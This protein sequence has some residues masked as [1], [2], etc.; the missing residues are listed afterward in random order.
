M[1]DF[2]DKIDICE[3]LPTN[4]LFKIAMDLSLYEIM[5]LCNLSKKCNKKICRSEKFWY[6]KLGKDFPNLDRK[7]IF[8]MSWKETY[9]KMFSKLF[10]LDLDDELKGERDIMISGPIKKYLSGIMFMGPKG[11]GGLALTYDNK[12]SAILVLDKNSPPID[13][14]IA[15]ELSKSSSLKIVPDSKYYPHIIKTNV[16]DFFIYDGTIYIL[17]VNNNSYKLIVDVDFSELVTDN[18]N[19][20]LLARNV[21]QV[22]LPFIVSSDGYYFM[23][24]DKINEKHKVEHYPSYFNLIEKSIFEDYD[25]SQLVF[26]DTQGNLYYKNNGNI[27]QIS[28][29]VMKISGV[30]H[31]L[32]YIDNKHDLYYLELESLNPVKISRNVKDIKSNFALFT[33]GHMKKVY[34]DYMDNIKVGDTILRNVDQILDIFDIDYTN[35]KYVGVQSIYLL[36]WTDG[37]YS[38]VLDN[39][40]QIP[41]SSNIRDFSFY[42]NKFIYIDP[43][44]KFNVNIGHIE[45]ND[46]KLI[47]LIGFPDGYTFASP[48]KSNYMLK[49]M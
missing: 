1:C 44:L 6:F 12:L 11:T 34:I 42:N 35:I 18:L 29:N 5:E 39:M 4:T 33:N 14:N 22:K 32:Y 36:K 28:S 7:E 13:P 41:L 15:K 40:T 45:V 27:R 10:K 47:T 37:T 26:L 49:F 16:K 38:L 31:D 30:L 19:L 24:Y 25:L 46:T 3:K 20:T 8:N 21:K 9:Q 48:D 17:D 2:I 43:N 23:G